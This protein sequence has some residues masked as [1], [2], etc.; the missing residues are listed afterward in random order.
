MGRRK[1]RLNIISQVNPWEILDEIHFCI[2]VLR[3]VDDSLQ[4]GETALSNL[5]RA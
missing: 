1:P 4:C 5:V 2:K 3:R